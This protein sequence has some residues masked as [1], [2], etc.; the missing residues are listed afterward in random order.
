QPD[1]AAFLSPYLTFTGMDGAQPE[2]YFA[3]PA[4]H[5]DVQVDYWP[6]LPSRGID[7]PFLAIRISAQNGGS[8]Y[9]GAAISGRTI[10]KAGVSLRFVIGTYPVVDAATAPPMTAYAAG[11]ALLALGIGVLAVDATLH[12]RARPVA[13]RRRG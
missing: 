1:G 13:E 6:G 9:E 12:A 3:V 11:M 7:I 10:T 8:L 2:D 5:R 4:L